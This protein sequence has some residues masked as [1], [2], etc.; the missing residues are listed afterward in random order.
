MRDET[1]LLHANSDDEPFRALTTPVH[2]ASTLLFP[3][4]EEFLARHTRFY[5]GYSY[6]LYGHPAS[7]AI[8]GQIADLEGGSRARI[9]PSS[10]ERRVGKE[11]GRTG[12]SRWPPNR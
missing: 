3:T 5:D 4:V 8:A 6:G 9:V 1:R 7:R 12:R 10:E 11:S 2:R